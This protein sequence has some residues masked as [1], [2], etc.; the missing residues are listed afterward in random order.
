MNDDDF[1]D[2]LQSVTNNLDDIAFTR[3]VTITEVNED[4]TVNCKED[5]GTVHK[6][7]INSTNLNLSR[8]DTVLLGFINNNIYDPMILGGVE[9][10]NADDTLIFALGLGKFEINSDG[11]LL[12]T[13]PIGVENYFSIDNNGDLIIDLDGSD[14]EENF[15]INDEGDVIYGS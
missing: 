8:D 10:K 9:V 5:N 12:L 6:N 1:L 15:S 7:V 3:Y 13:L 11:D 2:N 14:M 4:Q